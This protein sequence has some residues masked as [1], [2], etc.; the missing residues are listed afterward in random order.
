MKPAL[1]QRVRGTGSVSEPL[2]QLQLKM[3]LP[4]T[5]GYLTCCRLTCADGCRTAYPIIEMGK[6]IKGV[7]SLHES[8][9]CAAE[10]AAML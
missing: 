4:L 2:V 3:P 6:M 9:C 1:R 7:Q 10:A 5:L 8:Q